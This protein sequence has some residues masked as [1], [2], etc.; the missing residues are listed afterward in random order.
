[1]ASH[2]GTG[3]DPDG[4]PLLDESVVRVPIDE[5]RLADT[6]RLG[7][8]DDDHA[9][10]LAEVEE[11]LPPIYVHRE[12]MRVID[13]MH[14][15]RAARLRGSGHIAVRFFAGTRE[16]AFLLAVRANVAHGLPLTLNDRQAAAARIIRADPGLSDRFIA[17]TTGL[18]AKTV[19]AIRHR[20]GG[21]VAPVRVGRDGRV[22]PLSTAEGRRIA[23]RAIADRPDLSLREVARAAGISVGTARD[24][25][26]RLLAGKDPVP[27]RHRG[28]G[29]DA[30]SL[31]GAARPD[32][33]GDEPAVERTDVESIL[34]GLRRDPSLRYSESGRTLL[35][36]LA[37]AMAATRWRDAVEG[38]PP[39][40]AVL[41]GRI[42]RGYADSWLEFAQEMERRTGGAGRSSAA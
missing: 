6:P 22:R 38:V 28:A 33:N 11:C 42:A 18:A 10:T 24:V 8:V 19:A 5:L 35:R 12:T 40:C 13:G 4:H 17:A 30:A 25:R 41:V 37:S 7:G 26:A 16:E 20:T 2:S 21:A 15:L 29:N 27:V 14:R 9:R 36:W 23:G 39:H 31:D 32:G 1:M 34:E 3:R